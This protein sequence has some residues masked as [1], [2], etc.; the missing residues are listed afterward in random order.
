[1]PIELGIRFEKDFYLNI[2]PSRFWGCVN[3]MKWFLFRWLVII[4]IHF[5]LNSRD[6]NEFRNVFRIQSIPT[7]EL[8]IIAKFTLRI[9]ASF[10]RLL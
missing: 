6:D 9:Q 10:T 3:R 2:H 4:V 1:M 7:S 8:N 5:V